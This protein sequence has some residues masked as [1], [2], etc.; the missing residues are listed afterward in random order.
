MT[1]GAGTKRLTGQEGISLYAIRIFACLINLP[2]TLH[3]SIARQRLQFFNKGNVL[4][5]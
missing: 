3:E 1:G 5:F 2:G 4:I